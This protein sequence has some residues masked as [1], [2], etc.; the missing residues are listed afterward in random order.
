MG[1][2]VSTRRTRKV[3]KLCVRPLVSSVTAL[4]HR[5]VV[6]SHDQRELGEV[7][8]HTARWKGRKTYWYQQG[9]EFVVFVWYSTIFF[10][11]YIQASALVYGDGILED[12]QLENGTNDTFRYVFSVTDCR[13]STERRPQGD[14]WVLWTR[15]VLVHWWELRRSWR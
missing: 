12:F 5:Y 1:I 11:A 13:F 14:V 10:L 4:I 3:C 15:P 9:G 8:R 6:E 2:S 7:P